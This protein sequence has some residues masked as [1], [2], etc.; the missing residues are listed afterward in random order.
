MLSPSD[1][2]AVVLGLAY[3]LKRFMYIYTGVVNTECEWFF[4][5]PLEFNSRPWVRSNIIGEKK[6]L[7]FGGVGM[8]I[9]FVPTRLGGAAA[10]REMATS[11][12]AHE[13][14]ATFS[15][16]GVVGEKKEKK[17]EKEKRI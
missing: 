6:N 1:P 8:G 14:C 4:L 3:P 16:S 10:R 5:S 9:R 7:F 15:G 11:G 17:R 13:G 12:L 2:L